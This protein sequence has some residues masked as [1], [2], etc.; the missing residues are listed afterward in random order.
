MALRQGRHLMLLL[1]PPKIML[2]EEETSR[3]IRILLKFCITF[4]V[5]WYLVK[6]W[7]RQIYMSFTILYISQFFAGF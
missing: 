1:P 5:T 6:F 4:G 7:I 2:S 3:K